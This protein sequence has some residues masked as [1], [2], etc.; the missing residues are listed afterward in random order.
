M[1]ELVL[2]ID[3]GEHGNSADYVIEGWG[4]PELAHTWSVGQRSTLRLPVR[5]PKA[6]HVLVM[7]VLPWR[8]PPEVTHQT[9]MLGVDDRLL[10]TMG[11]G[12]DAAL[13]FKLPAP[14]PGRGHAYELSIG[15]LDSARS[16][17]IDTYRDGRSM[18]LM[19]RALRVIAQTPRVPCRPAFLP[20][21]PGSLADGS[22][23]R[24][25]EAATGCDI[26][27]IMGRFESLGQWCGLAV[28]QKRYGADHLGLLRYA[29]LFAPD[30]T[31]AI[32][33]RFAGLG[34]PAY[35]DAFHPADPPDSWDVH[36]SLHR[37]WWHTGR[38]KHEMDAGRVL[39]FEQKRLPFL[40]RKF[41][42][43][44]AAADKTM[45][46]TV[47]LSETEVDAVFAALDLWGPN[48]LLFACQDGTAPSGSVELLD[49]G[50]MRG[51]VDAGGAG[52]RGSDEAWFSVLVNAFLLEAKRKEGL[53]F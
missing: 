22:M 41:I 43:T 1:S 5:D 6:A 26:A 4:Q 36:D 8:S 37:I 45:V 34:D 28:L 50:K 18:G 42:E 49:D 19:M 39:A 7:R 29:G 44:I 9:V 33:R 30:L 35:L 11:I 27:A 47:A 2:D 24:A 48:T 3:F 15:H 16:A 25:A 46:L 12:E 17:R 52:Y 14:D 51:H 13:A 10:A 40:A 53:L 23:L 38:Y 32:F 20:P 21:L 31:E